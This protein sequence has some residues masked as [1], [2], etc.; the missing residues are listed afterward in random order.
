MKAYLSHL[1]RHIRG[2]EH[3]HGIVDVPGRH[4]YNNLFNKVHIKGGGYVGSGSYKCVFDDEPVFPCLD[5]T[6]NPVHAGQVQVL[7]PK[8]E[9]DEELKA[10]TYMTT[11]QDGGI[12]LPKQTINKLMVVVTPTTFVC[13]TRPNFPSICNMRVKSGAKN[14]LHMAILPK[15]LPMSKRL[16]RDAP[17]LLDTM[18]TLWRLSK[19]N[20]F[21]GDVKIDN[22]VCLHDRGAL[23]D[24]GFTFPYR[25]LLKFPRSGD[26]DQYETLCIMESTPYEFWPVALSAMLQYN[27][28][29][30]STPI[31][32]AVA[33]QVLQSIDKHGFI[34]NIH[35]YMLRT[36]NSTAQINRAMD[37]LWRGVKSDV[38]Y[39]GFV[40]E[41]ILKHPRWLGALLGQGKEKK[42]DD[43]PQETRTEMHVQFQSFVTENDPLWKLS[44]KSWPEMYKVVHDFFRNPTT[45]PPTLTTEYWTS[46]HTSS[47]PTKRHIDQITHTKPKPIEVNESVD[48]Q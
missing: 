41:A 6:P 14:E 2:G 31:I 18:Y 8:S 12:P 9:V 36:N 47:K 42:W 21:H 5:N 25:P 17:Y 19:N 34:K 28:T 30:P 38:P 16:M 20:V 24:F 37:I 13:K 43:V 46:V 44:F 11:S 33:R 40:E 4:K 48:I 35:F 32:G 29:H 26:A 27:R 1:R 7:L 22:M 23:I 15:G 3:V 39:G 45:R 10:Y